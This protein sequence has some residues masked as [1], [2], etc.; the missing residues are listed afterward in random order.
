VDL[1]ELISL[2]DLADPSTLEVGQVL[3]VPAS[4]TGSGGEPPGP[5][6]PSE[7]ETVPVP[8]GEMQP[9]VVESGDNASDIAARFGVTLQELADANATTIDGLRSLE[10]G[11]VLNIPPP[12]FSPEPIEEPLPED[13][14][15]EEPPIEEPPPVE[16]PP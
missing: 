9:Y 2:N 11:Q 3:R 12:S 15:V 6:A 8:P 1:E 5:E 13:P 16:E 14:P 7:P 4:A 10:V